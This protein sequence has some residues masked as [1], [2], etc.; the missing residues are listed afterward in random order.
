MGVTHAQVS[1][2]CNVVVAVVVSGTRNLYKKRVQETCVVDS[3]IAKS[4]YE[5]P[6]IIIGKPL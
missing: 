6:I 4:R 1:G 5:Y 2:T 3:S